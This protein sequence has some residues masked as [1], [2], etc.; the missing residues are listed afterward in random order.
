MYSQPARRAQVVIG[1]DADRIRAGDQRGSHVALGDQARQFSDRCIHIADQRIAAQFADRFV[2]EQER[3]LQF[4]D[5]CFAGGFL[6]AGGGDIF[7]NTV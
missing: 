3:G 2:Q 5:Q 6:L 4:F 1:H 7:E